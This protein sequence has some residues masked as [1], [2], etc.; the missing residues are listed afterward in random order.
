MV[1]GFDLGANLLEVGLEY[2]NDNHEHIF[3]DMPAT[4]QWRN[5]YNE[6]KGNG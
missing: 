5:A 3:H 4:A 6:R 2:L 1:V